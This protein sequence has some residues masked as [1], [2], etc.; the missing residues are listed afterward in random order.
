MGSGIPEIN[1]KKVLFWLA[2][3]GAHLLSGVV[4][5]EI[6]EK[7]ITVITKEGERQTL[8]ADTILLAIPPSSNTDLFEALKGKVPEVHL[9]GDAR[10]SQDIR[11]AIDDGFSTAY[12]L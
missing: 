6:S 8:E 1:R 11:L 5:E 10:E 2:K 3:K 12:S 7:G 4:Y 9:I